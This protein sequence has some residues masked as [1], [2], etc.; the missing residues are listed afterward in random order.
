MTAKSVLMCLQG[1]R[2][3]A[4]TVPG[5]AREYPA[6]W[7]KYIFASLP[8]KTAEFEVKSKRGRSR[9]RTFAASYFRYFSK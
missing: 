6:P 8:K 3:W 9:N 4:H 2:S 5:V 1:L 7:A